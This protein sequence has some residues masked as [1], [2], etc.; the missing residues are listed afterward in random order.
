MEQ[1]KK[2]VGDNMPQIVTG[3][4]VGLIAMLVIGT[5]G[6]GLI[7]GLLAFALLKFIK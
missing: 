5:G 1:A 6:A 7:V 4:A 3:A 2:Y